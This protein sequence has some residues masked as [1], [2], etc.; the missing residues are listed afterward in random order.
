[1][2]KYFFAFT[3]SKNS[4]YFLQVTYRYVVLETLQNVSGAS[5][6]AHS[7][8]VGAAQNEDSTGP[9]M[10]DVQCT[11]CVSAPHGEG[12]V[13]R[14]R[15]TLDGTSKRASTNLNLRNKVLGQ[16]AWVLGPQF[17]NHLCL[18]KKKSYFWGIFHYFL[19]FSRNWRTPSQNF[20]A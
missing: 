5:N 18:L 11:F 8:T 19:P 10:Q 16:S 9:L 14:S 2:L 7:S 4:L 17:W 15:S 6:R 12:S 3:N 1:M 20:C 13:L